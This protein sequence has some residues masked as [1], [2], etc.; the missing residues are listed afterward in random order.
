MSAHQDF[1]ALSL[2][3][4]TV[5]D[6]VLVQWI[7]R[8][9]QLVKGVSSHQWAIADWM[10]WGE[11]HLETRRA[12]DYAEKITGFKRKTLREW[13]Y[14]ARHISIRMD[15]LSF[16]HHQVVAPLMPEAQKRCLE[17]FLRPLGNQFRYVARVRPGNE[18]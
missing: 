16:G 5:N 14:V 13:A 17:Y 10:L 11:M 2:E 15:N 3:R 1:D 4:L 9:A 8:G 18:C 6:P 12:Y 7:D